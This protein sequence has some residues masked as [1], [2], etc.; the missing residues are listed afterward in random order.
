MGN[1]IIR[2]L[3]YPRYKVPV[4]IKKEDM[5]DLKGN[6]KEI[7]MIILSHMEYQDLSTISQ[8]CKCFFFI[9]KDKQTFWRLISQ[10]YY[11]VKE[12]PCQIDNWKDYF[13]YNH[14]MKWDQ[15]KFCENFQLDASDPKTLVDVGNGVH[16]KFA[17]TKNDLKENIL[18]PFKL[19]KSDFSGTTDFLSLGFAKKDTDH[20]N[21]LSHQYGVDSKRYG[22][23]HHWNL[24]LATA[25]NQKGKILSRAN[26][27]EERST[28]YLLVH[29]NSYNTRTNT[30]ATVSFLLKKDNESTP[31]Y[32]FSIGNI[33]MKA[34]EKLYGYVC[35]Y[36]KGT[37]IKIECPLYNFSF[38][39]DTQLKVHK[40][41][42]K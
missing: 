13:R 12:L 31:Q 38:T 42:F 30:S 2:G 11:T 37:K 7:W 41:P 28:V 32:Q 17:M 8:V 22:Y 29:K 39:D 23:Y 26:K 10:R 33:D 21:V 4:E 25:S 24:K 35:T 1:K 20:T 18:Y 36:N 14:L 27:F 9:M 19:V 34:G 15:D 3:S 6:L 5:A 16:W 40:L